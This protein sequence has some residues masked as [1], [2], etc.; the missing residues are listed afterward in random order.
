MLVRRPYDE[1]LK[2]TIE[3][4]ARRRRTCALLREHWLSFGSDALI[5]LRRGYRTALIASFDE[6]KLPSNY[7]QHTDTA[8]RIDYDTVAA[9]AQGHRGDGAADRAR[10][11]RLLARRD[12]PRVL[13]GGDLGEQL[14]DLRAARDAELAARARRR[15]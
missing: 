8:D 14:A 4:A 11:T 6:H 9:A 15:G 12:L 1:A 2:D 5:A 3:A 13:R 7:H 10:L